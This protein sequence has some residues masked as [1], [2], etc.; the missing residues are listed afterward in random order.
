M[1]SSSKKEIQVN[2]LDKSNTTT[3]LKDL[4]ELYKTG[5]ITKEEFNKEKQKILIK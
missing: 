3:Q 5:A 4:F 1:I 2:A